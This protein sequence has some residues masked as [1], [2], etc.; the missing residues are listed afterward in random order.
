LHRLKGA[1]QVYIV[2][3]EKDV[4]NLERPNLTATCNPG[5]AGKWQDSYNDTLKGKD[6]II[7]PFNDESGRGH[8]ELLIKNLSPVAK[9]IKVV[10]LPDRPEKGDVSDWIKNQPD[11]GAAKGKL[12]ELVDG[13]RPIEGGPKDK[14]GC[15][16]FDHLIMDLGDFCKLDIPGRQS[17]I[18]P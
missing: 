2:E 13:Q 11:K 14:P 4:L 16:G 3:G 7:L 8:A 17:L 10:N 6:I 18:H 15:F 1:Q 12:L 9:S 5:G